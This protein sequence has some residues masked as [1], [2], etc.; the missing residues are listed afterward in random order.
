LSFAALDQTAADQRRSVVLVQDQRLVEIGARFVE[1][2]L[3]HENPAA[4]D[5]AL[6]GLGLHLNDLVVVGEGEVVFLALPVEIAASGI[7][8][9]RI[10]IEL[11]LLV[12][13][14][15]RPVEIARVAVNVTAQEIIVAML[16]IEADC[17]V[18]IGQS[19]V[20]ILF[21][22]IG[23]GA[24]E[25]GVRLGRIDLDRLVKL[26]ERRIEIADGGEGHGAN[27]MGPDELVLVGRARGD[28][29]G[30]AIEHFF[31]GAVPGEAGIVVGLPRTRPGGD[32]NRSHESG[33]GHGVGSAKAHGKP[34]EGASFGLWR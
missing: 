25:I 18:E 27:G 3:E 2:V 9:R 11:D 21:G 8:D 17:L 10:R 7:A 24:H 34:P 31:D 23:R 30:A 16:R 22:L 28:I 15:E 29:G 14:D 1:I 19:L 13:L 20:V 4:I 32:E 5:I 26:D 6:R 33:T 12:E